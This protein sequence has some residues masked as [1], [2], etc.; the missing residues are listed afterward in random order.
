[1]KKMICTA[2]TGGHCSG[3]CCALGH[4]G[5]NGETV[6]VCPFEKALYEAA[7]GKESE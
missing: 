4:T 6:W 3:A 7:S 1:M 5:R 2:K